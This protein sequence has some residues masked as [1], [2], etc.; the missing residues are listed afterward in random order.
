MPFLLTLGVLTRGY[1]PTEWAFAL[2]RL[3]LPE[4]TDFVKLPGLPFDHARNEV[5][6]RAIRNES[7]WLF[8]LDDDVL[9]PVDAFLKLSAWK[10]PIV[11]GLYWKRQGK[12]VPTAYL[13]SAG[14]PNPA[15]T[16]SS[17]CE[18]DFVG[19]G[20]LLIHRT[21][22]EKVPAPLFKWTINDE[23]LKPG[24]RLGED[25]N[26][27][28]KARAC[29]FPV[30]LDTTVRCRHMGEGWSDEDGKFVPVPT[31]EL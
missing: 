21:V 30:F 22:L 31:L 17:P 24:D 9:P 26:F 5:V 13:E 25:F 27:C 19:G 2:R 7:D 1:V 29:G 28:R 15:Q 23:S 18:V 8:F 3:K 10:K 11:S 4:S 12:I 6:K 20:C 16:L 14:G